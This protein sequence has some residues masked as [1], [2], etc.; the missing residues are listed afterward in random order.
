M[1]ITSD[2]LI[3]APVDTVWD[4][5]LDLERWPELTP[6]MTSVERLDTGPLRV[7]STARVVQPKQ[8]PTVWTVTELVPRA[9]FAWEAKVMGVRMRAIHDLSPQDGGC[10]NLLT[11]E[12]AGFGS[13]LLARLVGSKIREAITTENEG[14]R[15]AAEATVTTPGD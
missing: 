8:R 9:R 10:R 13:G 3:H 6:T 4:L 12:F 14:F 2:L 15:T 11:V 5:T 1:D 7:G